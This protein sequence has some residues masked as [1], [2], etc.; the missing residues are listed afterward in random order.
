MGIGRTKAIDETK[1]R[2]IQYVNYS[3]T[4]NQRPKLKQNRMYRIYK[5]V[6]LV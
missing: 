1:K 5:V 4:T 3:K 6:T 2:I